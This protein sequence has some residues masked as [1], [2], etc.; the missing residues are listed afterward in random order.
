MMKGGRRKAAS[1]L[2][3]FGRFAVFHGFVGFGAETDRMGLGWPS[4]RKVRYVRKGT[5]Q[6]DKPRMTQ[7]SRMPGER[8]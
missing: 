6:P 2:A 3:F 5:G 4:S 8:V 7:I 1:F